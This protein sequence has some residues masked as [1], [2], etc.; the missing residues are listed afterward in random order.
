MWIACA[1]LL[2]NIK[3]VLIHIS[4]HHQHSVSCF[5]LFDHGPVEDS[6]L[7][8]KLIVSSSHGTEVSQF[9]KHQTKT[10]HSS[11]CLVMHSFWKQSRALD[12]SSLVALGDSRHIG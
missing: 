2:V 4:P 3:F 8:S 1:D 5:F 11:G 12:N 6:Q 10:S 9:L 7:D